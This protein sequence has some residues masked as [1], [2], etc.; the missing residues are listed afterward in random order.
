MRRH[1][2]L[3]REKRTRSVSWPAPDISQSPQIIPVHPAIP[4]LA[5][6]HLWHRRTPVYPG[7]PLLPSSATRRE[8]R[9]TGDASE[10]RRR[11]ARAVTLASGAADGRLSVGG[12]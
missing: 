2:H 3:T 6:R 8:R 7:A 1:E 5:S 4:S 12:E 10:A 11:D 9:G